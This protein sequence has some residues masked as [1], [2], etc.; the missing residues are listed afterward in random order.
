MTQSRLSSA[1]LYGILDLG[2]VSLQ[3]AGGMAVR[4]LDGGVQILQLRAKKYRPEALLSLGIYLQKLCRERDVP[5]LINDYPQLA[6]ECGASGIHVGQDD[7]SVDA[8]RK[9]MPEGSIVGLST[10]S[11]EQVEH[12]NLQKPDYIGFGPLFSTPTKPDYTPV[13]LSKLK[14]VHDRAHFPVFCIGGIKREN[15]PGLLQAGAERVVIVSGI[16]QASDVPH[17]CRDCRQIL[18]SHTPA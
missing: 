7:V 15:L 3:E 14:E 10:H 9:L 18:D 11:L 12:S 6:L 13:G 2:Y 16:L 8:V 5:F 4:M 17:Y 1:R